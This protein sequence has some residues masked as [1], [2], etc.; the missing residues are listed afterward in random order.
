MI[1][2]KLYPSWLIEEYRKTFRGLYNTHYGEDG[3]KNPT[4]E[5][6]AAFAANCNL[7]EH[8]NTSLRPAHRRTLPQWADLPRLHSCTTREERRSD[9]QADARQQSPTKPQHGTRTER[10]G[11]IASR[12]LEIV[13][14][15]GAWQRAEELSDDV[16]A[17]IE[18]VL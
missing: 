16:A 7:R 12:E 5:E 18:G 4:T 8:G 15:K 1:Y 6:W 10:A 17:A 9:L 3:L 2:A 11:Q 13:R 14:I